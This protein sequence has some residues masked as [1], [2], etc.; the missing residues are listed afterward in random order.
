MNSVTKQDLGTG[1]VI[2]ALEDLYQGLDDPAI[3][4]DK[5]WCLATAQALAEQYRGRVAQ[6]SGDQLAGLVAELERL[7]CRLSRLETYAYLNFTTQT[8]D[9]PASALLQE[10]EELASS[11]G[12]LTVFFRLEWN[13]LDKLAVTS[14]LAEPAVASYAHYLEALR[15]FAPH[16]LSGAEEEL[17]Q[18][19]APVGRSA[20]NL[21]FD[22][23]MGRLQFGETGR[24]E[25]EVLNDLYSPRREVRRQAAGEMTLE[26]EKNSHLLSHVFNTLAAE[27][28]ISDRVRR[29]PG[30]SSEINLANE[31][32]DRTVDT[33]IEAVTAR[34]D[35]VQRY[36]R[37]KRELLGYEQLFD[38]DRY[39]PLPGDQGGVVGW[40][41]CR[42]MVVAAFS[43]F[44]P[45]MGGIAEQFFSSR[46]IHAPIMEGKRG[47]AFAHPC[48]PELHPYVMVNY[49]GS[50]RDVS[51]V[52]HEL[53]HGVH[54]L[55]AGKQGHY[56]SDTPLVL[57]ETA[58]VFA[59]FLVFNAQ[60]ELL[61]SG[62]ERRAFICQKLESIFATV[63]RQVAM[64]RF[65]EQMHTRRRERGELS[66]QEFAAIWQQTQ[67]AMFGDSLILTQDYGCWWSYI[68]HFLSTPGYVYSYAFGELLVL[69]LYARY[70][71]EGDRF[72]EQ[73]LSL[74]SAGGSRSPYELLAP[75]DIDLNAPSFWQAGLGIIE[76]LLSRVEAG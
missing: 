13:T 69:A 35:I 74:L 19:L 38:Y 70:Q 11:V 53:G 15:R 71:Q 39:A 64:N 41:S 63:F 8:G 55:L 7:D 16:Q 5:E 34:Y 51:T 61:G 42:Q 66:P 46:W 45:E 25:E 30:W 23:L 65:E 24:T 62:Q 54:Q 36:Y 21:L 3:G 32:E 49:T 57:A 28:M 27:K 14:L 6:L 72:V 22:K 60:L 29:Y 73:Y 43:D 47:G 31:L 40:Q 18:Q 1:E 58:S 4:R 68:P 67:E 37:L 26:L 12:Q 48:I 2:W 17:L 56:N 10:I 50:I 20:W 52:A 44:S 75:F 33:L 59:E 76:S 9:A